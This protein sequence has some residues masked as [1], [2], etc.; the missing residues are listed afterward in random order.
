MIE[1]RLPD[2]AQILD[3]VIL[4]IEIPE[5]VKT[6]TISYK[7]VSSLG[8]CKN[9][10]TWEHHTS[11]SKDTLQSI[12]SKCVILI[13][14][15]AIMSSMLRKDIPINI[16]T[17]RCM[18]KYVLY[19]ELYHGMR[20]SIVSNIIVGKTRKE[21]TKI[22]REISPTEEF[23]AIQYSIDSM[24][25]DSTSQYGMTMIKASAYSSKSFIAKINNY[26]YSFYDDVMKDLLKQ[27]IGKEPIC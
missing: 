23:G 5:F 12:D 9:E 7:H 4:S 10:F 11:S 25:K 26:E 17:L 6:I 2:F 16:H 15:T 3:E 20:H 18:F 22:L 8:V 13:N 27:N 14:P 24:S 19:H 21:V 1:Y